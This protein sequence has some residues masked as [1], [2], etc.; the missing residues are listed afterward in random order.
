MVRPTL[1]GSLGLLALLQPALAAMPAAIKAE[2]PPVKTECQQNVDDHGE[3]YISPSSKSEYKL[4]CNSDHY[5]GDL[6]HVGSESFLGCLGACD[7]NPDCIGY[8]YTPGNCWLKKTYTRKEVSTNVDFALNIKRNLTAAPYMDPPKPK[9]TTGSCGYYDDRD[10]P[11][12]SKDASAPPSEYQYHCGRDH[13]EGDIGVVGAKT[14]DS[15]VGFCDT[16]KDC[17]GFAWVGGNGPGT[18]YL[19]GRITPGE[20]NANVDFASKNPKPKVE[21]STEVV[22][23]TS[24]VPSTSVVVSTSVSVVVPPPSSSAPPPLPSSSEQAPPPASSSI[25]PETPSES[26]TAHA[27]VTET[28]TKWS[29]TGS[30]SVPVATVTT[31]RIIYT[32]TGFATVPVKTSKNS[33]TAK[34]CKTAKGSKSSVAPSRPSFSRSSSESVKSQDVSKTKSAV[35]PNT[36]TSMSA[37][38]GFS[39]VAVRGNTTSET[40]TKKKKKKIVPVFPPPADWGDEP[41]NAHGPIP[42]NSAGKQDIT[43]PMTALDPGRRVGSGYRIPYFPPIA[44]PYSIYES[45][46][47]HGKKP[48]SAVP[49][50]WFPSFHSP[51]SVIGLHGSYWESKKHHGKNH[52]GK[53]HHGKEHH[54]NHG[55]DRVVETDSDATPEGEHR[56]SHGADRVVETDVIA[57]PGGEQR[58]SHGVD[59]AVETDVD[60]APEVKPRGYHGVNRVGKTRIRATPTLTDE[61]FTMRFNKSATSAFFQGKSK[62]SA[63]STAALDDEPES[64]YISAPMITRPLPTLDASPSDSVVETY[65]TISEPATSDDLP[66]AT[67]VAAL[68]VMALPAKTVVAEPTKL[69]CQELRKKNLKKLRTRVTAG[70]QVFDRLYVEPWQ[71]APAGSSQC[72]RKDREEGRKFSHP[73]ST[74]PRLVIKKQKKK[75]KK[76]T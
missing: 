27:T 54:G 73:P 36:I 57:A 75:K 69:P 47:H 1:T 31:K 34:K 23:S 21:T 40:A 50:S 39:T 38:T 11:L 52:H 72:S 18:C 6:D 58:V 7:A 37:P 32:S 44:S 45:I 5:G 35:T 28:R 14:F 33:K 41:I 30:S 10:F 68:P 55:V 59:R 60:A 2:D 56:V 51:A 25:I 9:P 64:S 74:H 15:C 4:A 16:T 70:N 65:L 66:K 71:P 17:I 49:W 46:R 13:P 12:G 61:P 8:A 67:Y 42:T 20:A 48:K 19:K 63:T 53:K 43:L 3:L 24:V 26:S 22:A 76:L 29:L 62:S